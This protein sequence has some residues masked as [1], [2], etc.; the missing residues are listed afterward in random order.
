MKKLLLRARDRVP[1][2][3]VATISGLGRLQ[4][5]ENGNDGGITSE[6]VRLMCN[7]SS[8]SVRKAAM[9]F[10][11]VTADTASALVSRCRDVREDVRRSAFRILATRV[12]P[13]VLPIA[14]RVKT[15][16]SGLQD[17]SK[18][19]R[20]A[21]VENL[22]QD[23]WLIGA[24]EGNLVELIGQLD[25][26]TYQNEALAACRSLLELMPGLANRTV[27]AIDVQNLS[28]EAA[29]VLRACCEEVN[30]LADTVFESLM[31]YVHTLEGYSNSEFILGQLLSIASI[32]DQSEEVGRQTLQSLLVETVLPNLVAG[33]DIVK[34]SVRP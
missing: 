31:E 16:L 28:A 17:R 33:S 3:R 12:H 26:E 1:R 5:G 10:T 21:C 29:L 34:I 20:T 9:S 14:T 7:D 15:L 2:V 27:D 8:P 6:L 19:V 18:L 4:D 25:P 13:K 11:V 22:L 30:T 32:V 24:C 23:G